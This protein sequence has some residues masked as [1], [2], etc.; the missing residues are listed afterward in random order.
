MLRVLQMLTDPLQDLDNELSAPTWQQVWTPKGDYLPQPGSRTPA[1]Q[2]RPEKVLTP[3]SI[4]VQVSKET[5]WTSLSSEILVC[6]YEHKSS[7][8]ESEVY[9]RTLPQDMSK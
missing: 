1:T 2:C 4:M 8:Q 3:A 7:H 9:T 5:S 6:S